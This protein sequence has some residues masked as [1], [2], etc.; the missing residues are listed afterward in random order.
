[1]VH[2]H[3]GIWRDQVVQR[4]MAH[5]KCGR[6]AGHVASMRSESAFRMIIGLVLPQLDRRFSFSGPE[7][8]RERDAV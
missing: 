1:M 8:I 5:S 2:A 7:P 4:G 3:Q 6:R